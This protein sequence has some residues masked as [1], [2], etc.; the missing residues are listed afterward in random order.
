MHLQPMLSNKR[1]HCREKSVHCNW[2][3]P[4]CRN[5]AL[6][7]PKVNK[8]IFKKSTPQYLS[9]QT[10]VVFSGNPRVMHHQAGSLRNYIE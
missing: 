1:S 5:E 7:K 6:V 10:P 9:A 4:T 3:K 8:Q 2:G